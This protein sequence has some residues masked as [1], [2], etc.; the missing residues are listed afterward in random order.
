VP[1]RSLRP[2]GLALVACALLVAP[3]AASATSSTLVI[4]QVY[5]GS[6]AFAGDA[7]QDYVELRNV[8]SSTVDLAGKSVQYA[9]ATGNYG[10]SSTA[11]TRLS[12]SVD[13][14][15][16]V[17]VGMT[18]V[19]GPPCTPLSG[20]PD[21]TGATNLSASSG[22][23][24]LANQTGA[25]GCKGAA[26]SAG[27]IIDRVSYGT[28]DDPE[29]TAAPGLTFTTALHRSGACADTDDNGADFATTSAPADV[30]T[31][32]GPPEGDYHGGPDP[33]P[34][35]NPQPIARI[36]GSGSSTPCA[37]RRVTVRGVVTGVDDQYGATYS[38]IYRD[39]AGIWVQ[40]PDG[41][42]DGDPATSEGLVGEGFGGLTQLVPAGV[43][44]GHDVALSTV[45]SVVSSGAPLPAPVDVDPAKARAQDG[46]QPY[47]ESL[48]GMRV[49]LAE[50]IANS[51]GTNKFNELY[52]QPGTTPQRLFR[53]DVANDVI[54]LAA[55][56]GAGNPP[57]PNYLPPSSTQVNANLFDVVRDAVGPLTPVFGFKIMVQPDAL[58]TV[59]HSGVAFPPAVPHQTG[60]T[61]RITSFNV[62]NFFPPGAENDME[63]ITQAQY[64]AKR[65]A[66]VDAIN[67]FLDR[68][69]VIGLQEVALFDDKLNQFEDLAKTLHG[70]RAY[71]APSN[72]ARRITVGF[73]VKNGVHVDGVRQLGKDEE[74]G[75]PGT[76]NPCA[77]NPGE[78]KLYTRPPLA[79]DLRAHGRSFTY[80]TN[81]WASQGHPE[82]CRIA[83]G[84]Y[85]HDRVAELEAAGRDVVVGGD[86]NDFE[87]SQGLAALTAPGVTLEN[88]WSQAPAQERYS[89]VFDARLQTLDHLLVTSGLQSR[90]SD[91]RYVHFDNDYAPRADAPGVKVSDHDPPL[92]TLDLR[93][94]R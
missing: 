61:L 57:N 26:C 93:G 22:K 14:G 8:G 75:A 94:G 66:I 68:P 34:I 62:E 76:S 65:D 13:P 9:S 29:G 38:Q 91:F 54:G 17:L 2:L 67:S 11:V 31:A 78:T 87:D 33:C 47:Y 4:D 84:R 73:L 74:Y 44:S 46:S 72:D 49:R 53:G 42:D 36:Q 52:L 28:G 40:S 55:D 27:S 58:P 85:L 50:G 10:A 37:G 6:G 90:V 19:A 5:G 60:D 21:I 7:C 35:A 70:Y 81:H 20:S 71:Y 43:D 24:A 30:R 59:E 86:L 79:I 51:G 83:Q 64:E 82:A 15:G 69:D 45:G 32:C 25:L 89:Y 3:Q 1:L 88:L 92:L 41:A 56:A 23:V 77:D 16:Y 48:E 39:E 18:P 63:T 80:I 12:G